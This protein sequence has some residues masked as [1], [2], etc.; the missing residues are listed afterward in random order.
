MCMRTIS[1]VDWVGLHQPL[2]LWAPKLSL[3]RTFRRW[4]F[5]PSSS[6][7]MFPASVLT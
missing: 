7:M 3:Q 5:P 1:V 4:H 6:I 2:D